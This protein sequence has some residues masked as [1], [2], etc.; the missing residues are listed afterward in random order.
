[1]KK[2][3]LAL[4]A[5]L[6][7]LT[8]TATF[9]LDYQVPEVKDVPSYSEILKNIK[10][11]EKG[12]QQYGH[13]DKETQD[14]AQAL[15]E[16]PKYKYLITD[17]DLTINIAENNR[18]KVTEEYDVC[19][20]EN[21]SHG[22]F[23]DIPTSKDFWRENDDV[24]KNV[25]MQATNVNVSGDDY[26]KTR[27][28]SNI[29]LKIGNAN[30]TLRRGDSKHYVIT[31]DYNFGPD[32]L[33]DADEFYYNIIGSE[34][35]N[36]V[37]FLN[38]DFEINFPKDIK[39]DKIGF[40]HGYT[41]DSLSGGTP[42]ELKNN[43]S[44]QG[45]YYDA[46]KGGEALTIRVTLPEGYIQGAAYETNEKALKIFIAFS[47]IVLVPIIL[48]FFVYGKDEKLDLYT[49][50][51]PPEGMN[52]VQF[53]SLV[54]AN[55]STNVTS[56]FYYLAEQGFLRIEE[57]AKNK[58]DIIFV[59]EYD[60]K[61]EASRVLIESLKS[62]DK[63]NSGRVSI[64]KLRDHFY[65]KIPKI[66]RAAGVKELKKIVYTKSGNTYRFLSTLTLVIYLLISIFFLMSDQ[67]ADE[68]AIIALMLFAV[69]IIPGSAIAIAGLRSL[70]KNQNKMAGIFSIAFGGLFAYI[71]LQV[72]LIA[73]IKLDTVQIMSLATVV[74]TSIIIAICAVNGKKYTEEGKKIMTDVLSYYETIK[75]C[76]PDAEH[77]F[78]YFYYTFAFAFAAGL[79]TAFSK[80]FKEVISEPPNWY[81]G[82]HGFDHFDA[83]SFAHSMSSISSS[84]SSSPSSSG[85]GSSGGGS[86]GGGGGGGGGGGW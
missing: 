33:D 83:S 62:Y 44:V 11:R 20:A 37:I 55:S 35:A 14:C 40:T 42:F 85:G 48:F 63:N 53:G 26:E 23:R 61:D 38:T 8:P 27:E 41:H 12:T 50:Y 49:R 22:I 66:E 76:R 72:I 70:F 1:M 6:F 10:E 30:R 71:P 77:G 43:K 78:S 57:T 46:L 5:T 16:Y 13:D 34:W 51:D 39:E 84:S 65:T 68:G 15:L 67:Y 60:S 58:Y 7:A 52:P 4:I 47:I 81:S 28:N 3:F 31:Y 82:T 17:Y 74:T 80:R 73:D 32:N 54:N 25:K 19:F 79:S 45:H 18:Y 59:K 2:Y 29:H 75:S 56:L 21:G 64:S 24:T 86:S 9:A 69:F 36:D